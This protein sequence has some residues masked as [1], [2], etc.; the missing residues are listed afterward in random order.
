MGNKIC[1]ASV[2][3]LQRFQVRSLWFCKGMSRP[4]V[5]V[6]RHCTSYPLLYLDLV[7]DPSLLLFYI[8]LCVFRFIVCLFFCVFLCFVLEIPSIHPCAKITCH[9]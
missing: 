8:S 6:A 4:I 3:A 5:A 2:F 7:L 9:I 1:C